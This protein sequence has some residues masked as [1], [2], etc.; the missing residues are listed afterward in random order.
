[1]IKVLHIDDDTHFLEITE[2]FLLK[3]NPNW[4]INSIDD[5]TKILSTITRDDIL[6]FDIIVSDY[7]MPAINGLDLYTKIREEGINIPFIICTGKGREDIAIK[8]LNIGIDYY[9]QKTFDIKSLYQEL[10]HY[11]TRAV[12]RY[13]I[14]HE[15]TLSE[16]K[17]RKIFEASP[18]FIT[19]TR[20]SDGLI[21]DLNCK[22]EK[23]Y[24]KKKEDLIGKTNVETGFIT[25]EQRLRGIQKFADKTNL[26]FEAP[27]YY[28]DG[29]ITKGLFIIEKVTIDNQ[30]CLIQIAREI[31]TEK[32]IESQIKDLKFEINNLLDLCLQNC[33]KSLLEENIRNLRVKLMKIPKIT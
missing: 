16:E 20:L 25:E 8:A 5:P 30:E 15:G 23:F 24:G 9:L 18:Y 28:G 32:L 29:R 17:Y 33:D 22:A 31:S 1:M 3:A 14:E 27:M 4:T 2:Q 12:K 6:Q 10:S 13:R 7:Q 19:I 21:I 11:I 26:E